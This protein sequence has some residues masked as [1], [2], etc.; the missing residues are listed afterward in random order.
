MRYLALLFY[1]LLLKHLPATS[2]RFKFLRFIRIIRSQCGG[3]ILDSAGHNINIEK[4]ADFGTGQGIT[5]GNGS[6]IGRDCQIRGPLQIG[7]N[8]MM[9]PE[10]VIFTTNH[11]TSRTDI[12]MG[13]QGLTPPK[14]VIIGNDVWIGQRVMIM[15]GVHVGDGAVLAAGAV[16]TKDVPPYTIVAGVPAKVVKY[17][18]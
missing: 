17:R 7:D 16:V 15:P 1:L 18:K 13:R 10:V 2:G 9:G 3:I 6:G 4:G 14:K 5:I 12:P 11:V 8:V